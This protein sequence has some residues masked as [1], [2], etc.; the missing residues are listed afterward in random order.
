MTEQKMEG[1]KALDEFLDSSGR[2]HGRIVMVIEALSPLV[3]GGGAEGNVALARRHNV[4]TPAY[5]TAS[6]PFLSGNSIKH[7]IRANGSL[8][9]LERLGALGKGGLTRSQIQ[10]LISGGTLSKGGQSINLAA[11]RKMQ[12]AFPVLS[13][14]GYSAGNVMTESSIAVQH[15]ELVCWENSGRLSEMVQ[16]W[17]PLAAPLLKM[18]ASS[19]VSMEFGTR[20][21]PTR[22]QHNAELLKADARE[23]I[24]QDVSKKQTVKNADKGDSAQM[25]YEH[26]AIMPGAVLISGITLPRG[27]TMLELAALRSAWRLWAQERETDG[28]LIG[29][30]GGKSAVGMGRCRV[31]MFGQLAEGIAPRRLF[32]SE[33]FCAPLDEDDSILT[34]YGE[35][36]ERQRETWNADMLAMVE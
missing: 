20:H 5:K 24:E 10:L 36:M 26:E 15:A 1:A 2:V 17:C 34:A 9:A 31:R 25:I 30:F 32:G 23:E 27:L 14:C 6:V 12:D 16:Q 4:I 11:A 3:H 13:L 29:T 18:Y 22:N 35:H 19:F 7:M 8:Y 28:A 21:E 33:A